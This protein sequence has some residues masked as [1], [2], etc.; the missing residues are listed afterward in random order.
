M[1][2]SLYNLLKAGLLVCNAAAVLHPGRFLRQCALAPPRAAVPLPAR[3][4]E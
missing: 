2:L 3:G 4:Q 1:G